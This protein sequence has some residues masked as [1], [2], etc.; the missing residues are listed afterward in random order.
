MIEI[1]DYEIRE[2][3]FQ[4]FYCLADAVKEKF[5]PLFDKLFTLAI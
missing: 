4:F 3:G 1:D 2:A 5:N